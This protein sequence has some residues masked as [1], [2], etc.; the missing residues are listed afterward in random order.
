MDDHHKMALDAAL[1]EFA[2]L[3]AE[4]IDNFTTARTLAT[5]FATV[6][7]GLAGLVVSGN[8][9]LGALIILPILGLLLWWVHLDTRTIVSVIGRYIGND[10]KHAV[11]SSTGDKSLF[12]WE[13]FVRDAYRHQ[14]LLRLAA[15][16]DGSAWPFYLLPISFALYATR[17][18]RFTGMPIL[19]KADTVSFLP[20][21]VWWVTLVLTV[22]VLVR[23]IW[24]EWSWWTAT[25]MNDDAAS[26]KNGRV[27][28]S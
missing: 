26:T 12:G 13:Q 22:V 6:S 21:W 10:L 23:A 9:E 16:F 17:D 18:A 2:A 14:G 3:R 24:A 27:A 28:P 4:I 11:T 7:V 1:G 5:L 20:S 8:L 15:G 19:V 25:K